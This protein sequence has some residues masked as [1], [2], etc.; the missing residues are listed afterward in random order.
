MVSVKWIAV[1]LFADG[2]GVPP[3]ASNNAPWL[4]R[5][6]HELLQL[7]MQGVDNR[8]IAAEL[9]ISVKTVANHPPRAG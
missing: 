6:Q 5:R 8:S 1:F 3:T 7:L 2:A 4:T 9:D